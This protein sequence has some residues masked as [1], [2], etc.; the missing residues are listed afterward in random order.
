MNISELLTQINPSMWAFLGV[1]VTA[2]LAFFVSRHKQK[3]E[4]AITL[5]QGAI[6]LMEQYRLA[7]RECQDELQECRKALRTRRKGRKR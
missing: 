5:T 6:S 3:S 4:G 7:N 2:I 1:L